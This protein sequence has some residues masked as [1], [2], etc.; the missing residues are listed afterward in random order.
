[1]DLLHMKLFICNVSGEMKNAHPSLTATPQ[2]GMVL[3]KALTRASEA[4]GLNQRTVSTIIGASPATYSRIANGGKALDPGSKHWELAALLV[5]TYRSLSAITGGDAEAMRAWLHAHNRALGGIPAE[6][7]Q[8]AQG[9]VHV[10]AYL[11]AARGR[12]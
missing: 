2:A 3:S 6:R 7:L 8:T 10:L 5:R 4:L 9:L 11:D 1:M 12:N